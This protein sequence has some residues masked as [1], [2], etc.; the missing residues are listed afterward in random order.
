M[1]KMKDF[2]NYY[3]FPSGPFSIGPSLSPPVREDRIR[4]AVLDT[5]IFTDD[6]NFFRGAKDRIRGYWSPGQLGQANLN[7]CRDSYG[8]G[9]HVARI[10]LEVAPF[11]DIFIA[12]ISENKHLEESKVHY[13][14]KV[15]LYSVL[16]ATL[17]S[18]LIHH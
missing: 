6:D 5:G 16:D 9:T 13:I 8:H 4:I 3:I 2:C 15:R 12:K 14:A 7:D 11:A 18:F 10:L 17:Y 1:E